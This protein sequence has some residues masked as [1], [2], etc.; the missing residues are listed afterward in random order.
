MK[1]KDQ[2]G[3]K[4]FW[5]G[6]VVW[7]KQYYKDLNNKLINQLGV[8]VGLVVVAMIVLVILGHTDW[9]NKLGLVIVLIVGVLIGAVG[10]VQSINKHDQKEKSKKGK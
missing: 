4:S 3:K 5:G 1:K 10:T 2:Q 8:L 9:A 6:K 7:S